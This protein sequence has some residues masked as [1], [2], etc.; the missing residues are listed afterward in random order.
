MIDVHSHFLPMVDDGC[1][2][3]EIAIKLIE[4][5]YTLGV[6]QIILT[7]H[8]R[9]EYN[10]SPSQLKAEFE[11]FSAL[12]KEK[13]I[14][15]KLFLGQEIFVTDDLKQM[16]EN[17]ELLP[18]ANSKYLLLEFGYNNECDIAD[19]VYELVR[20]GYKPVIAH[21]ERYSYVS[22]EDVLEIKSLGG[23]IQIN[24]QSLFVKDKTGNRKLAKALI[25]NS[26]EK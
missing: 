24:A 6:E 7:P 3:A 2:S 19:V 16:L 26:F 14:P 1:D 20:M 25:K 11:K 10:K 5:A 23:L 8:F 18:L 4:Q 9:G 17:G 15:I 21:I 22:L 12:V 13:N